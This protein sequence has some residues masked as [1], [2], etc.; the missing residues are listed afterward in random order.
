MG[1]GFQVAVGATSVPHSEMGVTSIDL[2]SPGPAS[3]NSASQAGP[4]AMTLPVVGPSSRGVSKTTQAAQAHA[5]PAHL[6]R[7]QLTIP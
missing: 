7:G 4:A 3:K 5:A 2:L 1:V 6:S